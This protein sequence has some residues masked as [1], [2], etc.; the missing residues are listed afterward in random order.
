MLIQLEVNNIQDIELILNLARRLNIPFRQIA[1]T[2]EAA[3]D[4]E[5]AKRVQR[6][7]NFKASKPSAFGDALEWQRNE[8]E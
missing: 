7:L 1:N 6:I 4:D 5:R 8:R 3:N 2:P